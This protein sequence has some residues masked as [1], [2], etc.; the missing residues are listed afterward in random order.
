V[1]VIAEG[2]EGRIFIGINFTPICTI[3]RMSSGAKE[4]LTPY[5]IALKTGIAQRVSTCFVISVCDDIHESVS[6][7]TI[8]LFMVVHRLFMFFKNTVRFPDVAN[9]SIHLTPTTPENM[10]H[11]AV[12]L[13][14]VPTIR[15]PVTS[16]ASVGVACSEIRSCTRISELLT[17]P[18]IQCGLLEHLLLLGRLK[19]CD[20][21]MM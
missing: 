4:S 9:V 15:A 21:S 11:I 16:R 6:S 20:F 18:M 12:G 13:G 1:L 2:I 19:R 5:S 17:C 14:K 3:D 8:H 10:S 7:V